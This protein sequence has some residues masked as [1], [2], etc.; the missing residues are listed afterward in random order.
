MA[1][2]KQPTGLRPLRRP[3]TADH[4]QSKKRPYEDVQIRIDEDVVH[5]HNEALKAIGKLELEQ[6][7]DDA[8][9]EAKSWLD[10]LETELEES[11]VTIRVRSIGRKLY[12]DLLAAHP[13]TE[14]QSEQHRREQ[15]EALEKAGLVDDKLESAKKRI[16]MAAPYNADTFPVALIAASNE[17]QL[18][19]ADIQGYYDEWNLNEFLMLWMATMRVQKTNRVGHWGKAS[20]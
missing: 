20:G 1:K 5:E 16:E 8:K 17:N 3:A 14:A 4:L 13:P 6:A 2:T 11:T 19:E 15:I 7:D 10:Q 12:E 18:T 9:A